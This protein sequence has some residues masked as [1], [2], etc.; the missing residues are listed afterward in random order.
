MGFDDSLDVVGIHGL[1]G[2]IGTICLG[3]FASKAVNPGGA[4]G[5]LAGNPAF[6][7][8]QLFGIMVV[9]LYAFIVSWILCKVIDMAMGMRL[10]TDS[11]MVGLDQAEHNETAYNT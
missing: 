1:G 7:G 11:E 8:T 2:L 9:G 4:D 3:I 6:L 10:D 5:L